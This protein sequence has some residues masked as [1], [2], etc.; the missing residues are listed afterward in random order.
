MATPNPNMVRKIQE[1]NAAFTWRLQSKIA[2]NV[3]AEMLA[4]LQALTESGK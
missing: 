2:S 3:S 1:A 4:K